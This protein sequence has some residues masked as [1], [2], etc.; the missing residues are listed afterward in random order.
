MMGEFLLELRPF[1]ALFILAVTEFVAVLAEG[2][3]FVEEAMEFVKLSMILGEF[4]LEGARN[5]KKM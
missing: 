5:I 4:E 2:I 1:K 3:L